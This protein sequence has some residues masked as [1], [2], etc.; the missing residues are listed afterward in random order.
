MRGRRWLAVLL[1]IAAFLL[2]ALATFLVAELTGEEEP[3]RSTEPA[4]RANSA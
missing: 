2:S 4:T 3:V 1:V